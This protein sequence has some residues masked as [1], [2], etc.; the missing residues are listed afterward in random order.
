[1]F[2]FNFQLSTFILTNSEIK[3]YS[4]LLKKKERRQERKF[5]V[6]GKRIL[7]DALESSYQCE[8]VIMTHEFA[9]TDTVITPLLRSRPVRKEVISARDFQKL[10]DTE[11]PQGV[12]G[13]FRMP[14][15][16]ETAFGSSPL[17]CALEGISD[18]GNLGTIIR[19]CDWFGITEILISGDSTELYSPKS[20]RSTMGSVFHVRALQ[21]DNFHTTLSSLKANGY[22]V[23]AADMQGENL[24]EYKRPEKTIITMCS[25]ASGPTEELL[26]VCNS[27]I[28]IP[29]IG[30]AESLNVANASAV[31]F[32][33]LTRGKSSE[34]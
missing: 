18:P 6:E 3:Y 2:T 26:R 21:T 33:Q 17:I 13:V 34:L 15:I 9:E 23:I 7:A 25:E 31:I 5:L 29:R 28:T 16:S 8:I 4:S 1:M 19:N 10:S 27:K 20:I 12:T 22:K 14:D 24:Y 11:H 30:R 32:S